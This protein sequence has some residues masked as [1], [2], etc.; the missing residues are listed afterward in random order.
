LALFAALILFIV[1][2]GLLYILGAN[3]RQLKA[4]DKKTNCYYFCET[5][6]TMAILDQARGNI[7]TGAGEWLTRTF[8]MDVDGK[9]HQVQYT[10]S[11][12][13]AGVWIIV[14]N[15]E[16]CHLRVGGNRAFPIFIR[17]FPGK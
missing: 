14:A 1:I 4:Y 5:G 11:R 9:S 3:L 10:V 13:A 8:T 15:S 7:G 2:T 6:V 17:G 16:G 12:D